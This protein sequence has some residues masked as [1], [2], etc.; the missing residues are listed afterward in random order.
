VLLHIIISSF[1]VDITLGH[2]EKCI[3]PFI[4]VLSIET[5]QVRKVWFISFRM[6]LF[7]FCFDAGSH[8]G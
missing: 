1:L 4:N 6:S 8:V 7:L 2:L 3:E 5:E